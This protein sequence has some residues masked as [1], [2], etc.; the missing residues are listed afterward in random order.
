MPP[1]TPRGKDKAPVP[2]TTTTIGGQRPVQRAKNIKQPEMTIP[3]FKPFRIGFLQRFWIR[4]KCEFAFGM[5]DPEE[6]V[7]LNVFLVLLVLFL[8]HLL[9]PYVQSYWLGRGGIVDTLHAVLAFGRA[10]LPDPFANAPQVA[11]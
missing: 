1:K 4:Y 7:V 8:A 3:P 2:P 6:T 11:P 9:Q 5:L 10:H